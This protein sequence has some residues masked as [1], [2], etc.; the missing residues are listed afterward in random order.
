M[1]QAYKNYWCVCGEGGG[2][3]LLTLFRKIVSE[4]RE[5]NCERYSSQLNVCR[6]VSYSRCKQKITSFRGQASW[7]YWGQ[8]N[9]SGMPPDPKSKQSRGANHR[10]LRNI[11]CLRARTACLV[12]FSSAVNSKRKRK[13]AY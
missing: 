11:D 3:N 10:H 7:A 1:G 9:D 13:E 5:E 12:C 8:A 4:H 2:V 6:E